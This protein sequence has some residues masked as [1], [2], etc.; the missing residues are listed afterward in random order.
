MQRHCVKAIC[1]SVM[2]ASGCAPVTEQTYVEGT[3]GNVPVLVSASVTENRTPVDDALQCYGET[4]LRVRPADQPLSIA[5]GDIRDFTGR[6]NDQEGAA[7]TQGAGLMVYSSLAAMG[8][9]IR[10]NERLDPRIAELE[11]EY[12]DRQRLGDG[13]LHQASPSAAPAPWLPYMG[14]S[15]LQSDY[16]IVGG[17]TELNHNLISGG[18][19]ALIGGV[20]A[21]A[22]YAV[23]NVAVDLRIV[24][25]RSLVVEHAVSLQKQVIGQ[26]VGVDVFR[27]FGTRLFDIKGGLQM[28]EPMQMAVRTILQLGTLDLLE[29]VSGVA[30]EPCVRREQPDLDRK[31][32]R[33]LPPSTRIKWP[34]DPGTAVLSPPP[35]PAAQTVITPETSSGVDAAPASAL[36]P[37]ALST[38]P[39]PAQ[40]PTARGAA[41]IGAATNAEIA[42]TLWDNMRQENETLL[43]SVDA[44]LVSIGRPEGPF[45][46][47]VADR[48]KSSSQFCADAKDAGLECELAP[49]QVIAARDAA[50]TN[51]AVP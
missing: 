7:I 47:V 14:G 8:S 42:Q 3:G 12:I 38:D 41:V 43:S 1:L 45:L 34:P 27:F 32:P 13:R 36:E 48:A 11:L 21:R 20:G 30:N 35:T 29:A 46:I 31:L 37:L 23:I 44:D 9:A 22:R 2:F 39:E 49:P 10:I 18:A 40:T 25:S 19:E 28:T 33:P 15:I 17:V 51:T 5:V 50:R 16:Y 24:N 4:L 6:I 26:E